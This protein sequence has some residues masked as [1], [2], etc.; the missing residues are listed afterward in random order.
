MTILT[1][2]QK[3]HEHHPIASLGGTRCAH[4]NFLLAKKRPYVRIRRRPAIMGASTFP[5][6]PAP[7]PKKHGC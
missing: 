1:K 5:R 3:H 6:T 4:F 7:P 2:L